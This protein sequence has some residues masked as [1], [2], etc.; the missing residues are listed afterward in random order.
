MSEWIN[1][2]TFWPALGLTLAFLAVIFLPVWL[3][4][5]TWLFG[6]PKPQSG[7]WDLGPAIR[8]TRQRN[9]ITAGLSVHDA[10]LA[11]Q[12]ALGDCRHE[13]REPVTLSTGE[14]VAA[15]CADC[16]RELPVSWLSHG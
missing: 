2:L 4:T 7:P 11:L 12:A 13:R 15:V 5:T 8:E 3:F 10:G 1:G 6:P 16:L 9:A 14:T